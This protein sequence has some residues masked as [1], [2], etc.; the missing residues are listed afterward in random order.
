VR[1]RR[2]A[3]VDFN[4]VGDRIFD[5]EQLRSLPVALNPPTVRLSATSSI[6]PLTRSSPLT[7]WIVAL[8]T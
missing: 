6:R 7:R 5:R 1:G 3:S 4:C 8:T 2:G